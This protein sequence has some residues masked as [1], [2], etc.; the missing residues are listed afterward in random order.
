MRR[1]IRY[2]TEKALSLRRTWEVSYENEDCQ[3]AAMH[4][5][6]CWV[7]GK[8]GRRTFRADGKLFVLPGRI[9]DIERKEWCNARWD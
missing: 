2:F 5:N 9:L 7:R 4:V 3:Y 6:A 8:I 1:A